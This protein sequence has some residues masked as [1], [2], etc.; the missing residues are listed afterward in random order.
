RTN[1]R[2]GMFIFI[3]ILLA[4]MAIVMGGCGEVSD[5]VIP[6][7]NVQSVKSIGHPGT[8]SMLL[9]YYNF[10][11]SDDH[12]KIEIEPVRTVQW[13]LNALGIIEKIAPN[14]IKILDIFIHP[15][16]SFTVAINL[17][18]PL[19]E[20]P[21]YTAFDV[22]GIVMLPSSIEFPELGLTAPTPFSPGPALLNPE[23]YTRRW[24][25]TEF[26]DG[27]IPFKYKD[28]KLIPKGMGT[29]CDSLINPFRNYYTNEDRHFFMAGGGAT[30]HYH[31][32][33]PPK[34]MVFAYAIDASWGDPTENIA[35]DGKPNEIPG[36]FQI[37]ANSVE[38]Y[39]I[40]LI[41]TAG[42][43]KCALGEYAGGDNNV[44]FEVKDWQGDAD[45]AFS[46]IK[47]EAPDLFDGIATPWTGSGTTTQFEYQVVIPNDKQTQ[48][49]LYP[50]LVSVESTGE[51]DP[52]WTLDDPL[53]AY[54]MFFLQ[55]VEIAPPFCNGK[56]GVHNWN[57]GTWNI[58]NT[59]GALHL[60]CS[61]LPGVVGGTGAIIFD[62]GFLGENESIQAA[63][64][65]GAG[66]NTNANT[67]I[68]RK[69][70]YAGNANVLQANQFN[71]H[72]ILATTVDP[73]NILVYKTNGYLLR[74]Y[75]LG[76]GQDGLNEPI[77]LTTNPDNGDIWFVG[78]R[79]SE[80]I[81][82]ERWAYVD[83]SGEF[84]YISDPLNLI[85]LQPYLD[86]G[87]K[88]LGIALNP[89]EKMLYIFHSGS[90]GSIETFD[91]STVPPVH[92]EIYSS[93]YLFDG[94]LA[95]FGVTDLRKVIGADLA[96]DYKDK[97][98]DARCRL[99]A[100]ATTLSFGTQIVRLDAWGQKLG[101]GSIGGPF[102]CMAIN[103][104]P[105][106]GDRSAVFFKIS[107]QKT[108]SIYLPPYDW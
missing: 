104:L 11:L 79:G 66:G 83:Q 3:I 50:L 88:V 91:F 15:D 78:N 68:Q 32:T 25:P 47:A 19:S 65:P 92:K 94:P 33:F 54:Q 103:N 40:K 77:A 69:G 10:I 24:N 72:I 75:D 34:G 12:T 62:G 26:S 5:P 48:P 39:S 63:A 81:F 31:L 85:D 80:G 105:D 20:Y 73:D 49:G 53:A 97:G 95:P 60:D 87:S 99:T 28:G 76:D 18:S 22:R 86:A 51:V 93:S 102:S 74:E 9:G 106:V 27:V 36:S 58:S 90:N 21:Q 17:L 52:Y 100:F 46:K 70:I 67:L 84:D 30:Q 82:L 7:S 14:S 23:G 13:H 44:T 8:G 4:L 71:G 38:P 45:V 107:D 57:G 55:V 29:M 98:K 101:K 16:K 61:F 1:A 43:M 6:G 96:L 64:I 35:P 108:Y 2:T 89:F 37:T 59:Y 42:M 41:D 56:I